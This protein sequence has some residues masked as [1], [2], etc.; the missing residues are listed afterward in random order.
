[1]HKEEILDDILNS[2]EEVKK[3][4][5]I[6]FPGEWYC[7]CTWLR[8]NSLVYVGVYKPNKLK[9]PGHSTANDP[10]KNLS[11]VTE[12]PGTAGTNYSVSNT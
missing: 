4:W 12:N 2:E 5:I 3:L 6:E 1:M 11:V 9:T 7:N 10:I 8:K